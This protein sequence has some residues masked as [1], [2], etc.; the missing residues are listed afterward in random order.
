MKPTH[1][2]LA[3]ALLTAAV[4]GARSLVVGDDGRGGLVVSPTTPLAPMTDV[5]LVAVWDE[6]VGLIHAIEVLAVTAATPAAVVDVGPRDPV[7]RALRY[8]DWLLV[9]AFPAEEQAHAVRVIRC[10]TRGLAG[11]TADRAVGAAGEVSRI[12]IHPIWWRL[13]GTPFHGWDLTDPRV[14]GKAAVVIWRIQGWDA[15]ACR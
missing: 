6:R 14:A 12:Q 8:R 3:I 4:L 1:I 9:R 2:L 5:R 11:V 7:P 13:P 15:W 10:E